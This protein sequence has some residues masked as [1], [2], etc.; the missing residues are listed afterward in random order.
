M[1]EVNVPAPC[2]I[3]LLND[4]RH[5]VSDNLERIPTDVDMWE[6]DDSVF[7]A[8]EEVWDLL[9]NADWPTPGARANGMGRTIKS[10][11]IAA[12]RPR[13]F[14]VLDSVVCDALGK[15][16]DYWSAFRYALST[17]EARLLVAAST[18]KAPEELSLLRAI[19]IAIWMAERRGS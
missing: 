5:A 2:A 4:G 1:L 7:D 3:W 13:L 10:K 9:N 18:S 14:P 11:L 8:G 17:P 15:Q 12:K 16:G 19:D 6:A